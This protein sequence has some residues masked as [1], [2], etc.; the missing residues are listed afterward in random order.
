[1]DAIVVQ[2]LSMVGVAMS[3]GIHRTVPTILDELNAEHLRAVDVRPI[4]IG[5]QARIRHELHTRALHR[6]EP[7]A[8]ARMSG[9]IFVSQTDQQS[10]M[11]AAGYPPVPSI[12][13]PSGVRTGSRSVMAKT[14][15]GRNPVVSFVG[16][17]DYAP[18]EFGAQWLVQDVMPQVRRAVTAELHLIGRRP[19]SSISAMRELE[20]VRLYEDVPDASFVAPLLAASDVV[21]VPIHHGGGTKLKLVE[22]LASGTPVVTTTAGA[23]GVDVRHGQHV[24]IADDAGSFAA[25]ILQL[26]R[27]RRLS[28]SLVEQA[29]I[30]AELYSWDRI[31]AQ[32]AEFVLS[33]AERRKTV[34]PTDRRAI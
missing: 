4:I 17:F 26:L 10:V 16:A 12:V 6:F 30:L 34:P 1:M 8:V 5:T 20:W 29:R 19:P 21:V 14:Q 24:L 31:G 18:N 28:D 33:V 3:A 32:Y 15:S 25:A 23:Q 9:C 2:E 27:D 11:E 13:L 22:G 7:W